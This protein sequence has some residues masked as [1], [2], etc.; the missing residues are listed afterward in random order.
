MMIGGNSRILSCTFSLSYKHTIRKTQ[1]FNDYIVLSTA[2]TVVMVVVVVVDSRQI[3]KNEALA[4]MHI[5]TY[6]RTNSMCI[7]R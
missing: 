5:H 6:V 7:Q 2:A 3:S 4:S 1:I